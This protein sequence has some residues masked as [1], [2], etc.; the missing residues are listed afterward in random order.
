[1]MRR[2]LAPGWPLWLAASLLLAGC[3]AVTINVS[4]P[5]EKL[6]SAAANIEDLVRSPAPPPPPAAPPAPPAPGRTGARPAGGVA[7][8]AAWL[9]PAPAEAQE[10]PELRTRTPEV[11]ASIESRRARYP[12]LAAAMARGC[13]GEN[14]QGLVEARPGTGCGADVAA[15]VAAENR[16]RMLL[17]RTLVEQNHMPPADLG[18][19]Q[20]AF[21]KSHRQHAP[22]GAWVQGDDGQWSRK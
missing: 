3:V 10:V 6:D 5:Q 7:V 13:V 20:A 4:F 21:A 18:R 17:Y 15:L 19:V 9:A 1:M 12:Q 11:M 8:L 16:D 2:A 22:A 14:R